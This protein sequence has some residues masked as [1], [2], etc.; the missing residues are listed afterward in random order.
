MLEKWNDGMVPF[1]Q[2]NAC[3]GVRKN[4]CNSQLIMK[5]GSEGERGE[6]WEGKEGSW[7]AGKKR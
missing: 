7:E 1:G 6:V 4:H 3:G 2:I 5:S